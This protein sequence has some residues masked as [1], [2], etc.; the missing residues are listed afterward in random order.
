MEDVI[1]K[2]LTA[3]E[4]N[5]FADGT[6]LWIETDIPNRA[7]FLGVKEGNGIYSLAGS[8]KFSVI[9]VGSLCIAKEWL[10]KEQPKKERPTKWYKLNQNSLIED[11]EEKIV[12][13]KGTKVSSKYDID[14]NNGL[15]ITI[16][17][18]EYKGR[19]FLLSMIELDS[20]PDVEE[21]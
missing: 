7:V 15:R 20:I 11:E 4:V 18:G 12:I 3:E 19:E 14:E 13:T 1:G 6:N 10:Y 16:R 8:R 9:D 21:G 5:S 2:V 17:S